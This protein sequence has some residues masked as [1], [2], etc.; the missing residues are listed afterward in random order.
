M[1][2]PIAIKQPFRR[3]SFGMEASL[4]A[5]MPSSETAQHFQDM[6]DHPV[7]PTLYRRSPLRV[8]PPTFIPL[9]PPPPPLLPPLPLPPTSF[10]GSMEMASHSS[11]RSPSRSP[12]IDMSPGIDSRKIHHYPIRSPPWLNSVPRG[13]PSQTEHF[14]HSSLSPPPSASKRVYSFTREQARVP[15][16]PGG[17]INLPS[18]TNSCPP[19]ADFMFQTRGVRSN[20]DEYNSAST[21]MTECST[22]AANS[23]SGQSSDASHSTES[24]TTLPFDFAIRLKMKSLRLEVVWQETEKQWKDKHGTPLAYSQDITF[25]QRIEDGVGIE[26]DSTID[27]EWRD[28]WK[29]INGNWTES[30][31]RWW[32]AWC[33]TYFHTEQ[34]DSRSTLIADDD[35]VRNAILTHFE[36]VKE[37]RR[38]CAERKFR[39][40]VDQA[41][42]K[43]CEEESDIWLATI[44]RELD[45]SATWLATAKRVRRSHS[46]H[47]SRES[48]KGQLEQAAF[49]RVIQELRVAAVQAPVEQGVAEGNKTP[50]P[51]PFVPS[52]G[53]VRAPVKQA[54]EQWRGKNK[55]PMVKDDEQ[56]R[57]VRSRTTEQQ[58]PMTAPDL[59]RKLEPAIIAPEPR[60][61]TTA[62]TPGEPP[63]GRIHF[64]SNEPSA[65]DLPSP[66]PPSVLISGPTK[67]QTPARVRT[68]S[69]RSHSSA[70]AANASSFTHNMT[71]ESTI[72]REVVPPVHQAVVPSSPPKVSTM[73]SQPTLRPAGKTRDPGLDRMNTQPKR[74]FT[75]TLGVPHVNTSITLNGAT[76]DQGALRTPVHMEDSAERWVGG[77]LRAPAAADAVELPD[78]ARNRKRTKVTEFRTQEKSRAS[79]EQ[80]VQRQHAEARRCDDVERDNYEKHEGE[81]EEQKQAP[82]ELYN[83]RW[84]ALSATSS[85][86]QIGFRDIPWPV[87]R[88]PT[89]PESITLQTISAFV[90][91]PGYSADNSRKGRLRDAMLQWDP[92]RFER[93]WMSRVVQDE[94]SQVEEAVRGVYMGLVQILNGTNFSDSNVRSV[95]V[96]VPQ[97]S[98]RVEIIGKHMSAEEIVRHLVKRACQDLTKS[99]DL[100]AFSE[101]PESHGGFSDVYQGRLITGV[102]VAVKALRISKETIQN[103]K[104][105]KRA[106]RELYTWSNCKHPNV[107]QLLGLAVF[108]GRIGMVSPWM[109]QGT[110]PHYLDN[111]AEVNRCDLCVQI[112]DGLA[113]LHEIGIVHGDL[114]GANILALTDGTPVLNDFGNAMFL[115]QSLQFT[116]TTR[117]G[118]LTARWAAPELLDE[119]SNCKPSKSADVYALGMTM[120]EVI[121]GKPPYDGKRDFVVLML[122]STNKHPERPF[123]C[124]PSESRDGDKFW[125]LLERCW[126]FNPEQRPSAAAV[127]ADMK[128]ITRQGL[129]VTNTPQR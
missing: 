25:R 5:T 100:S 98:E 72:V 36:K 93:R 7:R 40:E 86:E 37:K 68:S 60:P 26:D 50:K 33:R 89:G 87:L 53:Q 44:K 54:R 13:N 29:N 75:P 107:L 103:P 30:E 20:P 78:R 55:K 96:P 47:D 61:A 48:L 76:Q 85:N 95:I 49:A 73:P 97:E 122:V 99:L 56:P 126:T 9:S 105:L 119:S 102:H 90:L 118:S 109:D 43:L 81:N 123:K 113:Y 101:Y 23:D 92:D 35:G 17:P 106:A 124:I 104:H 77:E 10:L 71:R 52:P 79:K 121:T 115:G 83:Q 70:N 8:V 27:K 39:E 2:Q 51:P 16:V 14:M 4:K 12:V 18:R 41:Q 19:D 94:R 91:S 82:W 11:M 117:E 46:R 24:T 6:L 3:G 59:N 116:E 84:S 88:P 28:M 112:S 67:I 57:Q 128:S 15:T 1:Y 58:G 42:R 63:G 38:L 129:K 80:P 74:G 31:A 32:T 127:T 114:K 69:P 110:L 22:S 21:F 62:P 120:L 65:G 125:Q 108:R 45:E 66:T 111:N 34:S 64:M